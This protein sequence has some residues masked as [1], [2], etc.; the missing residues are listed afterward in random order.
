ML[1][2]PVK[3]VLP[4]DQMYGP[5]GHRGATRQTLRLGTDAEGHLTALEHHTVATTSSFD[6]FIEPARRASLQP[7]CQPGAIRTRHDAVRVDIGTPGPMRAP[8]EASGS[9]ALESAI[10]EAALA[11]GLDPLE[12]RLRNYAE[13]D[14]ATGKPVLVQ[15]AARMLRQGRRA[16]SAGPGGRS[17]RARCATMPATLSAGAWAR[18]CSR[19]RCSRPRRARRCAPTA[20]RSWRRRAPTWARAPGPRWPRS[21]PTGSG[22]TSTGSSSAPARPTCPTA[23][24][25]AVRAIR[26]PP[27]ARSTMPASTRSPSSRNWPPTTRPRRCSAP[28]M[29]ASS[30]ATA[31]STTAT[32]RAAA[33]AM[34]TSS[35][36]PA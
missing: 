6:D 10:D 9:A 20:P 26:R 8:G 12:F 14:P 2:R 7:L 31:G 36:A 5:V 28:A 29:P 22:S 23:A 1:R 15:G 24:S 4:R 35:P 32:T 19:R 27:A 13:T 25:P 33:R 18:R 17:R 30:H 3:L 21:P 11:C 16:R 34:S